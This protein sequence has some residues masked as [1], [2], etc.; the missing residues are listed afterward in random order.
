MSPA[1]AAAATTVVPIERLNFILTLPLK[2]ES[3]LDS[4]DL[5]ND[6]ELYG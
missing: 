3:E 1:I 5:L 4:V 2:N 6:T